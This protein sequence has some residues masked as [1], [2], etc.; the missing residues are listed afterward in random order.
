MNMLI[1]IANAGKIYT[2]KDGDIEALRDITLDIHAG[3]FTSIIGPSGC[4]KSTL[5]KCMSGLEK[6][7]SGHV[8]IHGQIIHEPPDRMGI[9][10]QR[11]VLLDWRTIIDNVLLP[12]EFA[13]LR[14]SD[15]HERAAVLLDR[16]GLATYENKRPWELS[17][18]MRQRAAICRALITDPDLLFMDEPFGA[19]DAMTR[20]DLNL[21]LA[22]LWQ[23]DQKTVLFITHSI[24]E[25]VFLSDEVVIMARNPGRIVE[26]VQID[27]PRPRLLSLRQSK[28]FTDCVA[29]IWRHFAEL[30]VIREN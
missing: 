10:F 25:A 28:A 16:F 24:H 11:D 21:E 19:L 13:G 15:Y 30:G 9:V 5:L 26:R 29:K 23:E 27:I 14:K 17:G 4:G 6:L 7:T 18:G 12:I 2:S 20:D 8:K 3:C 22:R 1:N